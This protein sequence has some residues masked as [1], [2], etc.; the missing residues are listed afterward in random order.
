[1]KKNIY[2]YIKYSQDILDGLEDREE[3]LEEIK[4]SS[5]YVKYWKNKIKTNNYKRSSSSNDAQKA[6]AY[7][8]MTKKDVKDLKN[9]LKEKK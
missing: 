8:D 5:I 6:F 2:K 9:K 1:M 3:I 7:Y 4:T